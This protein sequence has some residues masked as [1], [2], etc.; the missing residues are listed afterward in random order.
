MKKKTGVPAGTCGG[1]P[2]LLPE[3]TP[4]PGGGEHNFPW[5]LPSGL[6]GGK[7][8]E[9]FGRRGG[10]WSEQVKGQGR[11]FGRRIFNIGR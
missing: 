5:A 1:G 4:V 6:P 7:G 11:H 10:G 8:R 2:A 9:F 3:G